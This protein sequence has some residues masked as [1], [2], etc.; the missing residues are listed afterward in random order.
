MI[1]PEPTRQVA[2]DLTRA[3]PA[4]V[5]VERMCRLTDRL[6]LVALAIVVGITMWASLRVEGDLLAVVT[7]LSLFAL[8]F[9]SGV[10][11]LAAAQRRRNWA[12]VCVLHEQ[13]LRLLRFDAAIDEESGNDAQP[14]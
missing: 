1:V 10:R 9:T 14:S 5:R 13:A 7:R 8:G 4:M 2:C 3:F 11:A 6:E 12:R